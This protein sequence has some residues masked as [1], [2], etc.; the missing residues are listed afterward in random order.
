[1]YI[2]IGAV[3]SI[4]TQMLKVES[5]KHI[6]NYSRADHFHSEKNEHEPPNT[7]TDHFQH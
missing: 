5:N 4:S 1:M 2:N 6:A 7:D 3:H